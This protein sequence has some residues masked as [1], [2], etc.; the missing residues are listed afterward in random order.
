MKK[1]IRISNLDCANCGAKIE[2]EINKID[3]VIEASLN[4]MAGRL[5][6]EYNEEKYD[7][8]KEKVLKVAQKVEP[9]IQLLGLWK[10]T[11]T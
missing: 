10:R 2:R 4:F 9:D 5:I 6:L 11:K 3:G 1:Q 7:E 8:I